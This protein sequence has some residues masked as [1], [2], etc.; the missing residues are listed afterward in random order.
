MKRLVS[1]VLCVTLLLSVAAFASAEDLAAINAEKAEKAATMT[2][3][4]LLAAAKEEGQVFSVGM[5]PEWANWKDLWAHLQSLGIKTTDTDMSS[6]EELAR[7]ALKDKADADIG[8]IGIAMTSVAMEQDLLLPFK[9]SK[10]D[11]IP[12]WAKDADGKWIEAYTC[13]TAF[14]TDLENVE[15]APTS[16]KELLEG[17]YKVCIGD[18]EKASQAYNGVLACALAL[19]GDETNLQP[20][21]DAFAKLAEEGR[22]NTSNPYVA[23]LENGEI[24]VAI[25]WDFNA[26]GYRDQIQRDRFAVTIPSDGAVTSGY[27]SVINKYAKNAYA[28]MLT[29]EIMLSDIGQNFLALG[30]VHPIRSDA[31]L[32]DEAKAKLLDNAQYA[33]AYQIKDQ[34]AWQATLEEL[35]TLWQEQV[36]VYMN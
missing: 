18:V 4:E 13:T 30:Y 1:I 23:N 12:D 25:L 33:N 24:E 19:G 22:L 5:P 15:K 36:S 17:D 7:F 8:D 28:A 34:A 32:T 16:W 31:E 27:A 29:R 21:L 6:A 20:A 26:L 9:T 10:W 2:Y 35:P 3:D 11:S 14:I